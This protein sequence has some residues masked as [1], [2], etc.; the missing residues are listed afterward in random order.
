MIAQR[1][2]VIQNIDGLMVPPIRYEALEI[3]MKNVADFCR[4][5]QEKGKVQI[6]CPQFGAGLA[7][8]NWEKISDMINDIWS[9]FDVSIFVYG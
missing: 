6:F 1:D 2:I 8:G 7:G 4:V 5:W 9:D 3:C